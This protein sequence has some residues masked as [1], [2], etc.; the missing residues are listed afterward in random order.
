MS[1]ESCYLI[2]LSPALCCCSF[3]SSQ[4]APLDFS[5]GA[6]DKSPPFNARDMGSIPGQG[7]FHLP[8]SPQL[9]SSLC[10]AHEPPLVKPPRLKPA[11]RSK[12]SH[13]NEKPEPRNRKQPLSTAAREG[14]CTA[15][16]TQHRQ[17][18]IN[19]NVQKGSPARTFYPCLLPNLGAH[20]LRLELTPSKE[21]H[22]P[23]H[24]LL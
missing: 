17:K 1:S 22:G 20:L 19:G 10:R 14:P 9:L 18:E 6:V 16:E 13:C 8:R 21:P 24:Q 4:R 5:C 11:L 7:R 12:R 3:S 23:I 2:T 15:T